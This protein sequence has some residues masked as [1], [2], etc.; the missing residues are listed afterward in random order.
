MLTLLFTFFPIN[1][2]LILAMAGSLALSLAMDFMQMAA[3]FS[4]F[5]NISFRIFSAFS[6][7]V[8]SALDLLLSGDR[9]LFWMIWVGD[10]LSVGSGWIIDLIRSIKSRLSFCGRGGISPRRSLCQS[11]PFLGRGP[12]P[13]HSKAV[14]PRAKTSALVR[15]E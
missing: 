4:C 12:A 5:T 10:G 7:L 15:C 11:S 14:S 6:S 1:L 9:A 3:S 2:E 8:S 13:A